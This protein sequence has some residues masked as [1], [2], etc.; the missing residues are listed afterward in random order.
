MEGTKVEKTVRLNKF[1]IVKYQL[2][3]HCFISKIKITDTE[4]NCLALLGELGKIRLTEF[5]KKAAEKGFLGSQ[6]AVA[7]CLSKLEGRHLF[8]KAGTGKK[9][10]FL[11][12]DLKIKSEGNII[13]ELKIYKLEANPTAGSIQNN[14]KKAELTGAVR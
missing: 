7:S 3:H 13:L 6:I 9:I 5:N 4:L 14:S 8:I 1:E 10:I 11:N 2:I 12:P